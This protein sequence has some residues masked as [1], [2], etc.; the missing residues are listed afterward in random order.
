MSRTGEASLSSPTEPASGLGTLQYVLILQIVGCSLV[1][2]GHSYPFAGVPPWADTVRSFVY[3]FHMPLF[4]WCSGFLAVATNAA[5]KYGLGEFTKK[6]AMRLLFPYFAFSLI[7]VAPKIVFAQFLND[8][9]GLDWW[10][11]VV[12]MLVPRESIWGHFWF[13]PMLF[14]VGLIGYAIDWIGTRVSRGPVIAIATAL[15]AAVT[16]LPEATQWFALSDVQ[17]FLVYF[18]VGMWMGLSRARIESLPILVAPV[19]LASAVALFMLAPSS[20]K[21]AIAILMTTGLLVLALRVSPHLS[22]SRDALIGQTYQIFILS[23]PFQ[24]IVEII[25]ERILGVGFYVTAPLM[26]LA[27]ML[28]PLVTLRAVDWFEDRTGTHAISLVL[29]KG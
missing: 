26:F 9:L 23:W 7:G 28:L 17:H 24:L 8:K 14:L 25:T 4:V 13:L 22:I 27:G 5:S 29:G 12:A 11:L 15:A 10:D 1:I 6:R 3:S 2:L 21:I 18:L 19:S 16:F 20:S